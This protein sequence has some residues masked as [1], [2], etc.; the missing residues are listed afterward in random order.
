VCPLFGE[1]VCVRD[2]VGDL[3]RK[4]WAGGQLL[5]SEGGGEGGLG[6]GR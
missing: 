5:G 2:V 1:P 3:G 4:E 6:L